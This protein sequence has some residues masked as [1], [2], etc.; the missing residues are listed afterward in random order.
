MS[1]RVAANEKKSLLFVLMIVHRAPTI[2]CN[3]FVCV[4]S[5]VHF[6]VTMSNFFCMQNARLLMRGVKNNFCESCQSAL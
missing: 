2:V 6:G 3:E 1:L 5:F 4:P